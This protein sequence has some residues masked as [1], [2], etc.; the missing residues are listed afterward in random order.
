METTFSRYVAIEKF[1]PDLR[2]VYGY[3]S[4]PQLDSQGD[5]VSVKAI[6]D[7]LPDYM[8]FANI[9]EMHQRSAVGKTKSADIDEAGLY[10]GAKVVDDEAWKKVKEGVYNGFSIGG[11]IKGREDEVITAIDLVEISLVDRPANP[12]AV[13]DVWKMETKKE[14]EETDKDEVTKAEPT[15]QEKWNEEHRVREV[16]ITFL[17]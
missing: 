17:R 10:I 7:A 16:K 2:M 8:K 12:G 15:A 9:R 11:N 5:R 1:D 6:Q 13:F 3:A 14:N 4:T